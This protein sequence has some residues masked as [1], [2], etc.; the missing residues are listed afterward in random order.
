MLKA[1][2]WDNDGVLVDTEELYF[3]A[4]RAVLEQAGYALTV[5][6]YT[7]LGLGQGRS[8]FDKVRAVLGDEEVE[9]LRGVRNARYAERLAL[10]I[11]A[12]DGIETVLASLHGRVQMGVVTSSN[13]EHFE[14]IHRTT[15]LLRYFDFVLTN[16]DYEHTKPHP[17]GYLAALARCRLTPEQCIVI[18]DSERGLAAAR[19]AGLRCIVV[20][21]GLTRGGSFT[22]AY[23]VL[24][25]AAVIADVLAPLIED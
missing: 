25:D 10:G 20:P 23:R 13:A 21:R 11:T 22:G 24:D 16:G 12:L 19:A 15:G 6:E 8:V 17:A 5:A 2:F 18:V 9:R 14:I 1:V 7:D 4:T 3:D